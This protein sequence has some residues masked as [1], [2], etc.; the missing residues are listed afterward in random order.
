[1]HGGL[2]APGRFPGT[3]EIAEAFDGGLSGP[4]PKSPPDP[5]PVPGRLDP[6]HGPSRIVPE[7]KPEGG[8]LGLDGEKL[9]RGPGK[10]SRIN[11]GAALRRFP[12]KRPPLD[13]KRG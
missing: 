2:A 8:S 11:R 9:R 7:G 12:E 1:M 3:Q 6:C 13:R 4:F 10:P 5:S